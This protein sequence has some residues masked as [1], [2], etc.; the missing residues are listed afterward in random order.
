MMY[1]PIILYLWVTC[2]RMIIINVANYNDMLGLSNTGPFK[3][4]IFI[5]LKINYCLQ[6]INSSFSYINYILNFNKTWYGMRIRATWF[7]V[8]DFFYHVTVPCDH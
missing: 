3:R 1:T 8:T 2:V 5:L 4:I 7:K 6:I